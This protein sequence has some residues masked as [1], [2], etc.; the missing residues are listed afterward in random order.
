MATQKK[1]IIRVAMLRGI[2][3]GKGRTVPMERLRAAFEALG[4]GKVS[5][6]IQSGNVVFQTPA[7][8]RIADK[9]IEE[10]IS[11]EFG[12]PI[13]VLLR[14]TQELDEVVKGNPFLDRSDIDQSQLHVTFLSDTAPETAGKSLQ[15]LAGPAELFQV[16]G[17]EIYLYCPNGYGTTK[18]SNMAIEK[19]LGI[20]ATTRNWRSVKALLELSHMV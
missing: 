8:L 14:T 16:N 9:Q 2:N 19:K 3:V 4:F 10:R 18:L 17:R 13:S 1:V 12:F 7:D 15:P 6:Y 5:T 20:G 11:S